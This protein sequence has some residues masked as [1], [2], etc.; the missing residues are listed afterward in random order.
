VETLLGQRAA[1][2]GDI[3]V[4]G[5]PY[6][7]TRAEIERARLASLPEEP[8]KNACVPAMSV[9]DIWRCAP[10]ISRPIRASVGCD[11]AR[12]G[13]GRAELIA[14]FQVRTRDPT[15]RLPRYPAVTCSAPC[16]R[17]LSPSPRLLIVANPVFG[18]DSLPPLRFIND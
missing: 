8:L 1:A 3:E 18:L 4:S 15:R 11:A 7:G 12:C 9:A 5:R 16:G 13:P 10:L 17:E 6:H 2:S 14:S